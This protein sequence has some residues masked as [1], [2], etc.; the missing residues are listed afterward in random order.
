M[1]NQEKFQEL[2]N[3]EAFVK[4]AFCVDTVE[5][6]QKAFADHGVEITPE[7]IYAIGDAVSV[8]TSTDEELSEDALDSVAGGILWSPI[9]FKAGVAAGIATRALWNWYKG[10]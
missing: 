6:V 1:T 5:E 3:D 10:R 7:E 8:A 4:T 2:M 9:L